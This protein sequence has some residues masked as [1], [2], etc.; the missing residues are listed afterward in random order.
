M[1]T[2]TT[3]RTAPELLDQVREKICYTLETL[4]CQY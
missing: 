2:N 4:Q 1:P 3:L